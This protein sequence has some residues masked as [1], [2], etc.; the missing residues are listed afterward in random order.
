[1]VRFPIRAKDGQPEQGVTSNTEQTRS[2][3]RESATKR[4][5][6]CRAV[7]R[8]VASRYRVGVGPSHGRSVR[9][10]V[11]LNDTGRVSWNGGLRCVRERDGEMYSEIN[12][13]CC[14]V[15]T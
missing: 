8:N 3:V 11:L 12:E 6:G 9:K 7:G 13:E 10:K 1:M 2:V 5:R 4:R 14:D 15:C